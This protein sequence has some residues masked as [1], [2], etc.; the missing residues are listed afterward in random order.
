[1][2]VRTLYAG[3]PLCG[4]R[5]SVALFT[6][7]CS[8]YP[9]YQPVLSPVM[10]WMRCADCEH[11]YTDGY[12]GFGNGSLL[13]TV[14]EFGFDPVGID[15]RKDSVAAMR[16][17][18][19]EAHNT[20]LERFEDRQGFDVVSLCDVLEHMPYPTVGLE[21]AHALLNEGGLIFVS[22]P[23]TD[24][25]LWRDLDARN[26]N[27][28]WAELEHYHNFTRKRLYRLLEET[29]YEPLRYGVSERYR[30]CMDVLARKRT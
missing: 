2:L 13:F 17:F 25:T 27:P 18:G 3:C 28:Y 9:F 15:L 22:M 8:Q 1:M 16:A 26:V 10:T 4:G 7:D 29:G 5:N 24:S 12:H 19:I 11:V 20:D 30:V 14:Q 23:N 6:A 21:R